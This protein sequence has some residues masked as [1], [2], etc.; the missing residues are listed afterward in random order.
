MD[1]EIS[2]ASS[3][4]DVDTSRQKKRKKRQEVFEETPPVVDTTEALKKKKKKKKEKNEQSEKGIST[5]TDHNHTGKDF[6]VS[7][8]TNKTGKKKKKDGNIMEVMLEGEEKNKS[9]VGEKKRRAKRTE[10][11]RE[12]SAITTSVPKEELD[13]LLEELQEFLPNIKTRSAKHID[14]LLKYD[15][16]RFKQFKQQG[17]D[18]CWGRLSQQEN[19]QIRDNV[20]DFLALTSISSAKRLLFPQRYPEQE[21]QIKKLRARHHFLERIA[22]GIPRSCQQVYIRAK[23]MFDKRNYKGRFSEQEVHQLTKFQNLYGNDWKKISEM[24]G[25]SVFALE[26]RFAQLATGRGKWSPDEK[27]RLKRAVR[28]YLEVLVQQSSSGPR[29][30][31]QQLCNSLPWN[32]ISRKVGTR[33]ICQC[34]IKWFSIL[35]LKLTSAGTF[36]RGVEG[37]AA[38]IR[39]INTLYNMGVEDIADI[40]WEE[41]VRLVGK[42]T[43]V[44]VQRSFYRLKVS[45]VPNWISLSYGEIIDFLQLNV[46][47]ILQAKLQKASREESRGEAQGEDGFLL[48]DIV[49]SHDEDDDYMES[50]NSQLT[51]GQSGC[52]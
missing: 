2:I 18:L 10:G 51:F 37:I 33:S 29:L 22:E 49:P 6:S 3:A 35:R 39:L 7:M 46:S 34:R 23:K 40:D 42:V 16:H 43:P 41:V 45:K 27:S 48:S 36:T 15:L 47:P 44:C 24:M 28:D 13:W 52:R 14:R 25:R 9:D 31:R 4:A 26:K 38:K 8:E 50:D 12:N 17:V 21:K 32:V 11:G 30:S 19:Q 20:R 5:V 1:R